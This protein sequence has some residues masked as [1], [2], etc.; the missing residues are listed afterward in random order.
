MSA[1][2]FA[3][4]DDHET[5]LSIMSEGGNEAKATDEPAAEG[6]GLAETA[7]Q[8]MKAITFAEEGEHQYAREALD[9]ISGAASP[10]AQRCIL[11]LGNEDSFADYLVDYAI[12]MAERFHYEII[13]LNALPM[14][15]KTRLLKGY[16]NEIGER[17]HADA[18]RAG[19]AFSRKADERGVP[20][21]QEIQLTSEQKAIRHLHKQYG[22][23]EFVL[24]EPAHL[25]G[26]QTAECDGS[27]CVCSLVG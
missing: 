2:T 20:F 21:R 23:I 19:T 8:Y 15:R 25:A 1:I 12:D 18:K 7:Q 16:A 10:E 13:A 26:E 11:V 17:F 5:A 14:P 4:A 6:V 22:N 27:V 3:E 24:T 9:E